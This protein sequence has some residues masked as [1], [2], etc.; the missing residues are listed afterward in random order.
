M[1]AN[2]G[3]GAGNPARAAPPPAFV[4]AA[5]GPAFGRA[6]PPPA[7]VT[8]AEAPA[9]VDHDQPSGTRLALDAIDEYFGSLAFVPLTRDPEKKTVVYGARIAS[10]TAGT[11]K[12]WVLAF[13]DDEEYRS[14]HASGV[15]LREVVWRALHFRSLKGWGVD[16]NNKSVTAP[17]TFRPPRRLTSDPTLVRVG[18][19]SDRTM[20][21]FKD[22]IQDVRG[23]G[24]ARLTVQL[25]HPSRAAGPAPGGMAGSPFPARLLLSGALDAQS[26]IIELRASA[27][28]A[29][30]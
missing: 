22:D 16:E 1:S 12:P 21:A 24:R 28:S 25:L 11:E 10:M 4:R 14:H 17:Q 26:T 18:V 3:F 9:W 23:N 6:A 13:V 7:F 2:A 27:F 5:P 29:P 30:R 19:A 15:S 20:F 8:A